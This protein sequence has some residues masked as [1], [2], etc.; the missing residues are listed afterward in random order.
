MQASL[1]FTWPTRLEARIHGVHI[2]PILRLPLLET[3]VVVLLVVEWNIPLAAEVQRVYEWQRF[4]VSRSSCIDEGWRLGECERLLYCFALVAL[5][6]CVWR[7]Q[8]LCLD[9]LPGSGAV[10]S[11]KL[12]LLRSPACAVCT[13]SS[14]VL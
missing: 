13:A 9:D 12:G 8:V 10:N 6:E 2:R 4:V 14:C 3:I 11:S 7:E 5:E 1:K